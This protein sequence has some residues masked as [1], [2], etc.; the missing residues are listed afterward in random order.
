MSNQR[1]EYFS[2]IIDITEVEFRAL[3]TRNA[4]ENF[5]TLKTKRIFPI[6]QV[7]SWI[8][9]FDSKV[10]RSIDEIFEKSWK[11]IDFNEVDLF[12]RIYS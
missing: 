4:I 11:I 12:K 5:F 2:R 10:I 6:A 1:K 3:A 8:N 9:Q 7:S